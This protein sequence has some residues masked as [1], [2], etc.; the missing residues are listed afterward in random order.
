MSEAAFRGWKGR[1]TALAASDAARRSLGPI[2]GVALAGDPP[3]APRVTARVLTARGPGAKDER[4][5]NVPT[6][7]EGGPS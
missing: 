5:L 4:G 7:A 1:P 3:D 6:W 2:M